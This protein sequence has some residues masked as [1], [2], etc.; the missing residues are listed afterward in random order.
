MYNVV[1]SMYSNS[2][3]RRP[4]LVTQRS[5]APSALPLSASCRTRWAADP[6]SPEQTR[7]RSRRTASRGRSRTAGGLRRRG[8]PTAAGTGSRDVSQERRKNKETLIYNHRWFYHDVREDEES[9]DFLNGS[10]GPGL[11]PIMLLGSSWR[12]PIQQWNIRLPLL[13]SRHGNIFLQLWDRLP[14]KH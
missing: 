10:F 6:S 8:W 11:F 1:Y 5:A 12:V 13:L 9:T 3:V 2:P 14:V 7:R 4:L